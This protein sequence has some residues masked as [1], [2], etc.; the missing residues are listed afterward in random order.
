MLAVDYVDSIETAGQLGVS[1][2][3]VGFTVVHSVPEPGAMILFA[4]GGLSLF[5]RKRT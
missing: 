1:K 5:R 3:L 4:L 2:D